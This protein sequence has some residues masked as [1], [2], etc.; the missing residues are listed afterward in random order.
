MKTATIIAVMLVGFLAA[1]Q[2]P[3][4]PTDSLPEKYVKKVL[5]EAKWGDGPGEFGVDKEAGGIAPTCIFIDKNRNIYIVDVINAKIQIYRENGN[6]IKSLSYLIIDQKTGKNEKWHAFIPSSIALDGKGFIYLINSGYECIKYNK[7]KNT[8]KGAIIR[9]YDMKG[10]YK[11]YRKLPDIGH[12]T[13]KDS[14]ILQSEPLKLDFK[15]NKLVIYKSIGKTATHFLSVESG[16]MS[17]I[18][19]AGEEYWERKRYDKRETRLA[20]KKENKWMY[21]LSN[22]DIKGGIE[23][24]L[25]F[26]NGSINL[27]HIDKNGNYYV[28]TGTVDSTKSIGALGYYAYYILKYSPAGKL[29]AIIE[30]PLSVWGRQGTIATWDEDNEIIY[31]LV[32]DENGIRLISNHKH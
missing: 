30:E 23:L 31:F 11:D 9:Q 4:Q 13:N 14:G 6:I 20:D 26:Y 28:K 10:N 5:I 17:N 27:E 25:P 2:C 15:D 8:I 7:E 19:T 29:L 18:I 21:C 1:G 3:G 24:D 16:E 32:N 22:N 12:I